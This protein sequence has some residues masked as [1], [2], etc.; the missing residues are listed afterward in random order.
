M[1]WNETGDNVS[2][3]KLN[4]GEVDTPILKIDGEACPSV[5]EDDWHKV[6]ETGE[7]S[8]GTDWENST[9]QNQSCLY[10]K[11]HAGMVALHIGA[12]RDSGKNGST[13]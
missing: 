1:A 10:R 8:Y 5:Y 7:I 13:I 2:T 12:L 3:G 11:N 9:Y 4:V 6:G